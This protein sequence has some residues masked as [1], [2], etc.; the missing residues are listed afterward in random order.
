MRIFL[1][2]ADGFIGRHIACHL[3]QHGHHVL[4]CARHPEAL[5]RMGF[6]TMTADLEKPVAWEQALQGYDAIVN[7]AGLLNGSE[8][9][10][11]AVHQDGPAEV[12]AAAKAAKL[13]KIVL[14]SAVGLEADTP[15]ARHR[16]AGEAVA[17]AAGIP[18]VILRPSM[19]LGESSYGGSSLLR[20]LAALPYVSPVV[21]HGAQEFDPI[22]VDDL[23][24]AVRQGIESDDLNGQIISPSGPERVTQTK[25]ITATRAWLG[26][27]QARVWRLPLPLARAMG[28]IGDRLKLG[29]ISS[30]AVRQLEQGV[31]ADYAAFTTSTGQRPRGVSEIL[32]Q[33]PSGS[34]DL[35][36]AR[37]YLLRPVIRFTLLFMWLVSGFVGLFLPPERFLDG[38]SGVPLSG[39]VLTIAARA[40][41]FIDV[42]IA[43]GLLLAWRLPKLALIQ[44]AMVGGYTLAFGLMAPALWLEP[45]GGLLKNLPI[46]C[47]ILVHKILEEER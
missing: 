47:L 14:I 8:P 31:T 28:W 5:A 1:L 44:M 25:L 21:G 22:H 39:E 12:Y 26:R 33:R 4:A 11:R 30:A 10:M 42:A 15:F 9:R 7:A 29:P 17:K 45:Y 32:A 36:H 2:G 13:R 19:V 18:A 24:A 35:W 6:E 23:A 16:R 46:L 20:A 41:G 34:Q 37:L 40:A 3:R 38:L 27:P 43:L